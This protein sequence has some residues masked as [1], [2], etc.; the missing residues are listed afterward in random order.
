MIIIPSRL[1]MGSQKDANCAM[2]EQKILRVVKPHINVINVPKNFLKIFVCV[3]Y[4][5]KIFMLI[6]VIIFRFQFIL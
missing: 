4:V 6:E 1:E 5:S 3:F 2:L